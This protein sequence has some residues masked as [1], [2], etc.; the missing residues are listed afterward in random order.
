MIEKIFKKAKSEKGITGQDL[1]IAIFILMMFLVLIL[2]VYS[3]IKSLSYEVRMNARA[4]D[5]ASKI[6]EKLYTLEYDDDL[7]YTTEASSSTTLTT[8]QLK[9]DYGV[10][11]LNS[12]IYQVNLKINKLKFDT[13]DT[14]YDLTKEI[15]I[16]VKYDLKGDFENA[17]ATE[18][19]IVR[20]REV[21]RIEDEIEVLSG[22]KPVVITDGGD[23]EEDML[24]NTV[25]GLL[26][27]SSTGR[28]FITTSESNPNWK[29]YSYF[30]NFLCCIGASTSSDTETMTEAGVLVWVPRYAIVNGKLAFL[31]K[32]TN[33][34]VIP[35]YSTTSTGGKFITGYMVDRST[36]LTASSYFSDGE[37]GKWASMLSGNTNSEVYSEMIT[38]L[39]Q[40]DGVYTGN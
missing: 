24:V 28:T 30:D 14:N 16:Q 15:I 11:G 26:P 12:N 29:N 19:K 17:D 20:D 31:Y 33:Y 5:T 32:D 2:S 22:Y 18:I 38:Y 39:V 40:D 1:I 7:F 25:E 27:T 21:V 6:A 10:T 34:P 23:E 35:I 8:A 3:N 4:A 9:N 36:T 13:E 37:R